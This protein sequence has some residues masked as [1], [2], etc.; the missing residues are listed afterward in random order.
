[1][2]NNEKIIRVNKELYDVFER[3]RIDLCIVKGKKVPMKS[4]TTFLTPD[5]KRI[6][7]KRH[8]HRNAPFYF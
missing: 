3:V 8:S 1:M 7:K 2:S 5:I 6:I 4:A